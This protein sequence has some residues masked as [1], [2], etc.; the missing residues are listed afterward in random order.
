MVHRAAA[1]GAASAV[2]APRLERHERNEPLFQSLAP[3]FAAV[4]LAASGSW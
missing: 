4:E 3:S 1:V 2:R